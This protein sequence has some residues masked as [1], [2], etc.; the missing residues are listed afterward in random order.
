M[1]TN[2][3]KLKPNSNPNPT[4]SRTAAIKS[5]AQ[6]F[7]ALAESAKAAVDTM[8]ETERKRMH[9]PFSGVEAPASLL[10]LVVKDHPDVCV[11][12][13]VDAGEMLD[14]VELIAAAIELRAEL[15]AWV[16]SLDDTM[17]VQRSELF[18]SANILYRLAQLDPRSAPQLLEKVQVFEEFLTRGRKG[19]KQ[20]DD[21]VV[22][23]PVAP[24]FPF[25]N[26]HANGA[27]V[28]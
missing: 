12:A 8:S 9:K 18:Q 16:R 11:R 22:I 13:Q 14:R 24:V 19:G 7:R 27:D 26:G 5:F 21:P 2:E 25:S 28:K 20:E 6:A 4:P 1:D 3:V 17:L 23:E 10:A 15:A